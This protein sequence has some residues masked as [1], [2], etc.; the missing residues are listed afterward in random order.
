MKY[1]LKIVGFIAVLF[2]MACKV[3]NKNEGGKD[4][5][6]HDNYSAKIDSLIQ[7]TD[8]RQF[9]GAILITQKGETK[10]SKTQGYSNFEE[11]TPVKLN[12]LFRI[13][14]NSK[15]ITAVL[16][17]RAVENGSIDL[18]ETIKTYLPDFKQSWSDSVSI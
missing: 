18:E 7:S 8:P 6:Q 10:Y 4:K 11:K 16:I 5:K 2:I 3:D 13:Q 1:N 12:D 15:Q 14:S 9:N 17:L